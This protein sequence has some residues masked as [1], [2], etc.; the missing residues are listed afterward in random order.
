MSKVAHKT[1]DSKGRLTLGG[2]FAG[3]MVEVED[4]GERVIVTFCRVVPERE[5]WLWENETAMDLVQQGI[6]DAREGRHSSGPDLASAFAFADEI[7]DD[8]D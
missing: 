2:R 7:P 1:L 3:R 5:A 4:T 8:E 6:R